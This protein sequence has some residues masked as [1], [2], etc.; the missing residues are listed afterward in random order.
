MNELPTLPHLEEGF[1][2]VWAT[3]LTVLFFGLSGWEWI[4]QS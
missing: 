2:G 3:V 4:S 1:S